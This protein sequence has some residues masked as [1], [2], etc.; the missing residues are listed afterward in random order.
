M[1]LTRLISG[2][3]IVQYSLCKFSLCS[4]STYDGFGLAW[5]ISEHLALNTKC[6]TFFA[7][8]FHELTSL[9]DDL[10]KG[11]VRNR[12]V[13][14]EV[15]SQNDAA[16][17]SGGKFRQSEDNIIMLYEVR[18]GVC[19]SSFGIQVAEM[20]HFPRSVISLAKAKAAQLESTSGIVLNKKKAQLQ[21]DSKTTEAPTPSTEPSNAMAE[22]AV[23][24]VQKLA[25]LSETFQKP[26]SAQEKRKSI[27][28]LLRS[29]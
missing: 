21:R 16:S 22:K 9:A 20:A 3:L 2:I 25:S 10:P 23:N 7:T 28:A 5:A 18:D 19:P 11:S 8:H 1:E 17:Q 12:H 14:A 26:L 6:F 15:V 24:F 27:V 13:T 4:T 29:L